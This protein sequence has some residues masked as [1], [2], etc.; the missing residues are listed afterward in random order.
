VTDVVLDA[1]PADS[2]QSLARNVLTRVALCLKVATLHRLDNAAMVQPIQSLLEA[3]NPSLQRGERLA[4]QSLDDNCYLNKELI[5]LDFSSTES[6]HALQGIFKRLAVNE[7]SFSE[8][9]SEAEVRQLLAVF[10]AHFGSKDPAQ[11]AK[12]AI[13]KVTFRQITR[14]EAEALTLLE[15]QAGLIRALA[16]AEQLE[17]ARAGRAGRP[18]RVR[19]AVHALA[20]A[21]TGNETMLWHL[22]RFDPCAGE[23]HFHLAAVAAQ[24]LLLGRALALPRA[25]LTELVLAAAFHDAGGD[26]ARSV[27]VNTAGGLNAESHERAATAYE[28]SRPAAP[29]ANFAALVAVACGFDR[30]ISPPKGYRG[31]YPAAA[32]EQLGAAAGKRFDARAVRLFAQLYPQR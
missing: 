29:P 15:G 5:R 3:V 21:S 24:C 2:G 11:F 17:A 14:A 32:L 8:P 26:P 27:L 30:L 10:Q 12:A 4:L 25:A 9:L 16:I 19:R 7:V 28:V 31:L 23:V 20:D 6:A 13:P 18:A 1:Q 22:A